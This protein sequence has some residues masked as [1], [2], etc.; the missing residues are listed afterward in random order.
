MAEI[1]NNLLS[2]SQCKIQLINYRYER[3]IILQKNHENQ[4]QDLQEA[5]KI[6]R[7]TKHGLECF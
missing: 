5:I 7:G 1:K 6:I 4:V 3:T 2:K